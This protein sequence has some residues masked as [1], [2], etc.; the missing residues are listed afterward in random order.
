LHQR[1]STGLDGSGHDTSV[2]VLSNWRKVNLWNRF[3]IHSETHRFKHNFC[4]SGKLTFFSCLFRRLLTLM[5]S[6]E[7]VFWTFQHGFL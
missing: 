4:A 5:F 1:Y 7:Q 3:I 6:L 2:L